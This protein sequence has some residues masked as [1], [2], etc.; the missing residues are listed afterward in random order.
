M[1]SFEIVFNING[2]VTSFAE[3]TSFMYVNTTGKH[4]DVY[5]LDTGGNRF[6][7]S[8]CTNRKKT[9]SYLAWLLREKCSLP[10]FISYE[11]ASI[12]YKRKLVLFEFDKRSRMFVLYDHTREPLF[13]YDPSLAVSSVYQRQLNTDLDNI[14]RL[15][16]R[17]SNVKL[18]DAEQLKQDIIS[19]V[20]LDIP[21]VA[22]FSDSPLE[23]CY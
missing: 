20:K 3:F 16:G 22:T 8:S 23:I 11:K 18:A 7:S 9:I 13:Q 12:I 14:N 10:D 19:I 5:F 4:H 2:N 21:Q 6:F 15:G 1:S 17:L